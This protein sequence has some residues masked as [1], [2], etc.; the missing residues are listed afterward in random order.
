MTSTEYC[1]ECG[2]DAN[3][4]RIAHEIDA[5]K[6]YRAKNEDEN[7]W[8]EKDRIFQMKWSGKIPADKLEIR[9]KSH[10]HFSMIKYGV[11]PKGSET[12]FSLLPKIR[13]TFGGR[14]TTTIDKDSYRFEYVSYTD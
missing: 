8:M 3:D 13:G 14:F 2:W 1:P 7:D 9:S 11:F 4:E 5:S 6:S 12:H 10:T